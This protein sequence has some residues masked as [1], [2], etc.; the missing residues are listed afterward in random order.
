MRKLI[1]TLWEHIHPM[2]WLLCA[3]AWGLI[4]AIVLSACQADTREPMVWVRCPDEQT[5]LMT[6]EQY[7][8]AAI[9]TI[10]DR[11]N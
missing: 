10:L 4:A 9:C 2:I 1:A 11:R 6:V 8:L 7:R 3:A 5:Y